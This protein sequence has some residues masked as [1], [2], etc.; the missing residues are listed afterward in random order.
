MTTERLQYIDIAKG[1]CILLVVTGHIIQF[2]FS[3]IGSTTA[4]S[5]IYS[6]HMPVFMLLSG[7]VAALS[8]RRINRQETFIFVRKKFRSLVV[9]FFVWGLFITPFVVRQQRLAD[10]FPTAKDLVLNPSCGAWFIVVLFCIQ[11]SFLLF[12]AISQRIN[13][14]KKLGADCIAL[15]FVSGLLMVLST[16]TN[17]FG[18]DIMG[19]KAIPLN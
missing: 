15:A 8:Q 19:G 3:G 13:I 14:R 4:F 9:P 16:C 7:Y 2:N 12:K 5:F 1:L 11:L 18:V 10:F 17:L 6:F